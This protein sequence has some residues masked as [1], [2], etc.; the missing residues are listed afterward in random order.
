[1][2]GTSSSMNGVYDE[3]GFVEQ[4]CYSSATTFPA[5]ISLGTRTFNSAG[6]YWVRFRVTAAGAGGGRA[7]HDDYV[8]IRK[9]N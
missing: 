2:V 3:S 5:A 7:L 6:K 9:L 4:T 1:M 8:K